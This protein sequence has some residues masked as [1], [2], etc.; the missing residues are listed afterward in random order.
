MHTEEEI[1]KILID[2]GFRRARMIGASKSY[3]KDNH[4]YH[5]VVFNAHFYI[6][7]IDGNYQE[8]LTGDI[9]IT[10]EGKR[11]KEVANI[12]KT[13]IYVVS[14][15]RGNFIKLGDDIKDKSIWNTREEIIE[16]TPEYVVNRDKELKEEA[17][18][19]RVMHIK[20]MRED[21]KNQQIKILEFSK[22]LEVPFNIIEKELV[23][24]KK[25]FNNSKEKPLRDEGK[26]Y[27]KY[28]KNYGYFTY[29]VL[30][31]YL[32]SLYKL[33]KGSTINPSC[34]W[35]SRETNKKLRRI[36]MEI[37]KMYNPDFN[38]ADFGRYVTCN[39]CV[40][41]IKYR[42]SY[43]DNILYIREDDLIRK[44]WYS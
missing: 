40:D 24:L 13:D 3:Y 19:R 23:E 44:N 33:E 10:L 28:F 17:R 34:V 8:I 31:R 35:L 15:H 41:A 18:E 6:I 37:E 36:D 1:E 25:E 4:K 7:N 26:I 2:K 29:S 38:Y 20:S 32:S 14:E 21:I 27:E 30:D 11:L 9:N 5:N 43:K 12:L 22:E 16:I 42:D 39:Y